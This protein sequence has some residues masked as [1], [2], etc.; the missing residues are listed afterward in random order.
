MNA[1]KTINVWD[2]KKLQ[3]SLYDNV[4]AKLFEAGLDEEARAILA[5]FDK[6]LDKAKE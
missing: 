3:D 5:A 6:V 2:A 4:I 1:T